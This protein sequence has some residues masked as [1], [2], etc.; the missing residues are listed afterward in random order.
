V[1]VLLG[2]ALSAYG[3]WLLWPNRA[4]T[5]AWLLGG[6]ILHDAVVAPLVGLAGL[7]LV[8][9]LPDRAV[10]QWVAAGLAVSGTLLLIAVP[11]VWRPDRAP[12][13]PGL[14]DRDYAPGLAIWLGATWAAVVLGAAVTAARNRRARQSAA[15]PTPAASQPGGQPERRRG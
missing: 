3:L 12:H 10:R 9:I 1:L 8:R 4:T 11:L 13:Y 15:R 7:L 2:T 14:N 6:P 5:A